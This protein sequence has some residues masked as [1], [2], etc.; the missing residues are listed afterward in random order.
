MVTQY[1]VHVRTN[2]TYM[3]LQG[4]IF[5]VV[6]KHTN[7]RIKKLKVLMPQNLQTLASVTGVHSC[8]C[9]LITK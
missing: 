4:H 5:Q 8:T 7:I 6:E 1:T 3:T 9:K 2:V